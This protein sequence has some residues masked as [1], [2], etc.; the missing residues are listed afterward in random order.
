MSSILWD[1]S[2]SLFT[3]GGSLVLGPGEC[4]CCETGVCS[5]PTPSG[6][7]TCDHVTGI[8]CSGSPCDTDHGPCLNVLESGMDQQGY[9]IY[10]NDTC[11]HCDGYRISE[12]LACCSGSINLEN[13]EYILY[14]PECSG[15]NSIRNDDIYI[16]N[17]GENSYWVIPECAPPI[18]YYCVEE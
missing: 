14:D 3:K 1:G 2:S 16:V 6:Y 10:Y 11:C 18:V 13:L 9:H 17:S 5:F 4:C 12:L 15:C 7:E 8:R